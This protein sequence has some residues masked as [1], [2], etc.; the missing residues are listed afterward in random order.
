LLHRSVGNPAK[1]QPQLAATVLDEDTDEDVP[2][3]EILEAAEEEQDRG[4]VGQEA[5]ERG[6]RK[7]REK[8]PR[9][10]RR[11]PAHADLDGLLMSQYMLTT[12]D[13]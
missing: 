13:M 5:K 2:A 3:Q 4:E 10:Y 8:A 1:V 11:L 6:G 7:K 12:R 9:T